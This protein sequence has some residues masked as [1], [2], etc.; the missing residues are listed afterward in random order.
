MKEEWDTVWIVDYDPAWAELFEREQGCLLAALNADV[1]EIEHIGSTAVP[2]L[3][4]KPIVDILMGVQQLAPTDEQISSLE[5]LGY[6]YEG[7]VLKIPEHHFFRK[8][9]PRTF[10]LHIARPGSAFWQRQILFRDFLRSH[11]D[12]AREYA[13]LKRSLAAQ[14]RSDRKT[15][16][17]SKTPL[18][19]LGGR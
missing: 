1:S 12:Q 18:V 15:Y 16:A 10:H 6:E 17:A 14:Y 4:A 8:G 11:P 5:Q 2:G 19:S 9:M 13:R 3:A 7:Q